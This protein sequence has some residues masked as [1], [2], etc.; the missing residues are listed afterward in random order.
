MSL[1]HTRSDR[2]DTDLG[3]QLDADPALSRVRVLEVVDELGK[4]FD[5]V[6]V[7]VR[8]RADQA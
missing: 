5:R 6:D 8:G 4:V 7:V 3:H 2:P 1:G